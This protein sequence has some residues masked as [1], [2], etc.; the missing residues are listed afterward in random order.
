MFIYSLS[1]YDEEGPTDAL[2]THEKAYSNEEFKAII[3][4][5]IERLKP[6]KIEDTEERKIDG[7]VKFILRVVEGKT[8]RQRRN[9]ADKQTKDTLITRQLEGMRQPQDVY[10]RDFYNDIVKILLEECGF[11]ELEFQAFY[12]HYEFDVVAQTKPLI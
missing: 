8:A 11:S 6:Q 5:I 4:S 3:D 12:D 2:L 10:F 7:S 1:M 9:E